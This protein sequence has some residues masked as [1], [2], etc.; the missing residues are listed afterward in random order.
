MI[1]RS[2]FVLPLLIAIS[3]LSL[4]TTSLK[5]EPNT[6]PVFEVETTPNIFDNIPEGFTIQVLEP[7]GGKILKPKD[8][9]Y[10]ESHQNNNLTWIISKE[11][12][13]IGRYDTGLKIQA[14]VGIKEKTGISAEDF[15]GKHLSSKKEGAKQIF[16][17][18]EPAERGL[19]KSMCI[20]VEEEPYRI[21]YSIF[22]N[23]NMD[24]GVI[25]TG[26][27]KLEDWHKYEKNIWKYVT[28]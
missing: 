6:D 25:M 3:S 4:Y 28:I 19:F 17:E 23:N 18:C 14:I 10:T 7:T 22:W 20:H 16:H 11:D 9:F 27:A 26:G 13:S 24:I 1:K 21:F 12:A 15:L 8:W 2:R 5:A